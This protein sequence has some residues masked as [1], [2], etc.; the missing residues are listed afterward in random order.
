MTG[1][2]EAARLRTCCVITALHPRRLQKGQR[3]RCNKQGAIAGMASGMIMIFVWKYLIRPLGGAFNI[4]ELLPAFIVSSLVIVLVS[5]ATPAPDKD[6]VK[7]F[8]SV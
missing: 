4:Y 7:E 8:E 2:G 6:I 3:K 5:L 1:S